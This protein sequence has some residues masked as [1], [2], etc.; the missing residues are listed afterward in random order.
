MVRGQGGIR[1][2]CAALQHRVAEHADMVMLIKVSRSRP[3]SQPHSRAHH[4]C[5]HVPSG[6]S[7]SALAIHVYDTMLQSHGEQL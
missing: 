4:Q 6:L 7:T 1:K 3:V 5:V 2:P